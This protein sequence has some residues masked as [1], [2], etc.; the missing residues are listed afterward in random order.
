[1]AYVKK[2]RGA[3]TRQDGHQLASLLDLKQIQ[4]TK[5]QEENNV[6]HKTPQPYNE[7]SLNGKGA[8]EEHDT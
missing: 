3:V 8:K 2:V 5:Q 7:V 6:L 4:A 1:M